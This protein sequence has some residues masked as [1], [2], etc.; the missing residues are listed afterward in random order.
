MKALLLLF[1]MIS[2]AYEI[3]T[4]LEK[5]FAKMASKPVYK[6]V[7]YINLSEKNK[8][9]RIRV[10]VKN[11]TEKKVKAIVLRFSI[12]FVVEKDTTTIE[13]VSFLSSHLREGEIKPYHTKSLY[14]Y[15]IKNLLNE[16]NKF[17]NAGYRPVK[18]KIVIMKEPKKDEGIFIKNFTFEIK[19][20]Q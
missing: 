13:T 8:D 20:N 10:D 1:T 5:N 16:L 7:D 3:E 4:Y 17:I 6:K 11:T 15:N 19:E 9:F 18:L 12:G 2:N 14:I